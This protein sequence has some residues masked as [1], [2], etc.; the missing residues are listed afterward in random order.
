MTT[1][2]NRY[3]PIV[4]AGDGRSTTATP[5]CIRSSWALTTW[6]PTAA[7]R[8]RRTPMPTLIAW[9]TP[10]AGCAW[11]ACT[12]TPT[13]PPCLPHL[14]T[15]SAVELPARPLRRPGDAFPGQD[16]A[17]MTP[18]RDYADLAGWASDLAQEVWEESDAR[19]ELYARTP[20]AFVPADTVVTFSRFYPS[21]IIRFCHEPDHPPERCARHV[22]MSLY[23]RAEIAARIRGRHH[24]HRRP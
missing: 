14:G 7:G 22:P 18:A 23:A 21:P 15:R 10:T 20:P 6:C 19:E 13:A 2:H 4:A 17:R 11:R 1:R 16:D 12:G 3:Y 9:C 8:R 5:A 24:T